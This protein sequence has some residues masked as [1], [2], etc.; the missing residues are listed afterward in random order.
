[1]SPMA[2]SKYSHSL[3]PIFLQNRPHFFSTSHNKKYCKSVF[4]QII[5]LIQKLNAVVQGKCN[6][7]EKADWGS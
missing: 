1:M 6:F 5:C 7:V 3:D 4:A 2:T